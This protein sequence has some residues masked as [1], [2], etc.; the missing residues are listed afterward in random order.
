M[1]SNILLLLLF[2]IRCKFSFNANNNVPVRIHFVHYFFGMLY[3]IAHKALL[4]RRAIVNI[5]R[6][7]FYTAA[8]IVH[9]NSTLRLRYV[10]STNLLRSICYEIATQRLLRRRR[11]APATPVL[12]H[13]N[14]VRLR[15][16][17][18]AFFLV[19]YRFRKGIFK[20]VMLS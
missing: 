9:N 5:E 6:R 13:S 16:M 8:S 15:F 7:R 18:F 3:C 14:A 2:H 17:A 4:L 10:A 11:Y 19:Y 12:R 20:I 1:K